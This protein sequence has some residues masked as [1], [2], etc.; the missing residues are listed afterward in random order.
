M[1]SISLRRLASRMI[2]QLEKKGV[3]DSVQRHEG[4][5]YFFDRNSFIVLL[6]SYYEGFSM[7]NPKARAR[8]LADEYEVKL[9]GL[10][11]GIHKDIN[12]KLDRRKTQLLGKFPTTGIFFNVKNFASVTRLKGKLGDRFADEVGHSKGSDKFSEAK[13]HVTGAVPGGSSVVGAPGQQ[14]AHGEF[15]FAVSATKASAAA[16]VYGNS[17]FKPPNPFEEK[18]FNQIRVALEEYNDTLPLSVDIIKDTEVTATGKFKASFVPILSG[19]AVE[20]NSRDA[21]REKAALKALQDSIK[22]VRQDLI[23]QPGSPSIKDSVESV[24]LQTILTGTSNTKHTGSG[25]PKANVRTSSKGRAKKFVKVKGNV[26]VGRDP[27]TGRFVSIKKREASPTS[28]FI[29]LMAL[30]NQQLPSVVAKNMGR[31]GL[32]Y[33]TGRFASSAEVVRITPTAEGYPSIAYTY[34]KQ[35]YEIFEM[36]LGQAPWATPDRD[37]RKV[38]GESVREIATKL[39]IG[40]FFTRRV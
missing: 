10:R 13:R 23:N 29:S 33:Q 27:K 40:R 21:T 19:Q 26:N 9:A 2:T 36:G 4:Q 7:S 18:A 14:T 24:I 5:L 37:P 30:I 35:P 8:K 12:R 6:T 15:G 17:T 22:Q 28:N 16:S 38:I 3:R 11:R 39:A 32:E 1:S 25:K 20:D 34:E 31:P